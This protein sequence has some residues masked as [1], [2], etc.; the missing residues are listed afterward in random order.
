MMTCKLCMPAGCKPLLAMSAQA[1]C[2]ACRL[3]QAASAPVT[4]GSSSVHAGEQPKQW[5]AL[6]ALLTWGQRPLQSC[7]PGRP[8][9]YLGLD[10]LPQL[11]GLGP[12]GLG[13]ARLGGRHGSWC[14]LT[15]PY[16]TN[17]TCPKRIWAWVVSTITIG[18]TWGLKGLMVQDDWT[19]VGTW[20]KLVLGF[21]I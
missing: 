21:R 12:S 2:R 18:G 7:G 19:L 1:A 11:A 5:A 13:L 3:Q 14:K 16:W 10:L 17:G 20:Q 4:A 9:M 6:H 8:Q 15:G